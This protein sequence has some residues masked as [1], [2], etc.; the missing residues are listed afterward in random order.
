M[1]S[2]THVLMYCIYMWFEFPTA[3]I[4]I[5][6]ITIIII[7]IIIIIIGYFTKS[8]VVHIFILTLVHQAR[9]VNGVL[10]TD[11]GP[12][13]LRVQTSSMP[14]LP[15]TFGT[16]G[17]ERFGAFPDGLVGYHPKSKS[18][19]RTY[20]PKTT[21]PEIEFRWF[22]WRIFWTFR[23]SRSQQCGCDLEH[24]CGE[25]RS[26]MV[27]KTSGSIRISLDTAWSP[28]L[29]SDTAATCWPSKHA[30]LWWHW[31]LPQCR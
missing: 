31:D 24:P 7:I 14:R 19:S 28:S 2:C 26:K 30:F 15:R 25:V 3:K 16:V 4:I 12:F 1:Y 29:S 10:G 17:C 13:Q 20:Q 27:T 23:F 22:R 21:G 18:R 8:F 9:A 6:I 11:R 5:I